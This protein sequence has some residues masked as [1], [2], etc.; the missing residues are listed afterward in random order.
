M[1]FFPL[2]KRAHQNPIPW[3]FKL[4]FL[5]LRCRKFKSYY[6]CC[7]EREWHVQS[8]LKCGNVIIKFLLLECYNFKLLK[9]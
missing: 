6:D 7:L 3:I 1:D 4:S 5:V 2:S 8:S 9:L